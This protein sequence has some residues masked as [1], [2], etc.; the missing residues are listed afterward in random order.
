MTP[1][2]RRRLAVLAGHRG[3]EDAARL[4]LTDDDPTVR[5]SAVGAL[6]R[7]GG[8]DDALLARLLDDPEPTVRRRAAEV[9]A[10]HPA[11]SLAPALDD[12]DPRVVEMAAFSCGEHEDAAPV[13]V[14]RLKALLGKAS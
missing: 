11:V 5:A 13:V 2:E 4:A 14:A 10:H 7:L 8:L 9:A 6:E 12:P 3:D 1:A